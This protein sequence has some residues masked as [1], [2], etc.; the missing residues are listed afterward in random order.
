MVFTGWL[1]TT[2][3][4]ALCESR[5]FVYTGILHEALAKKPTSPNRSN[6]IRQKPV[7]NSLLMNL[8]TISRVRGSSLKKFLEQ[9]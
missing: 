3:S 1:M 5:V 9:F 8:V 2:R 7:Q 4:T 6:Q